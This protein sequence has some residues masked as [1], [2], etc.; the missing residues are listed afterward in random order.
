MLMRLVALRWA[1]V[2]VEL[3]HRKVED[4]LKAALINQPKILWA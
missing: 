1:R 2:T 4:D 3:Y